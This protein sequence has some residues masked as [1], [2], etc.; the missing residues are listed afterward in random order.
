MCPAQKPLQT[1]DIVCAPSLAKCSIQ[2]MRS[3]QRKLL[4]ETLIIN[5]TDFQSLWSGGERGRGRGGG[6]QLNGGHTR[7][8]DTGI[9]GN[10]LLLIEEVVDVL[11]EDHLPNRFQRKLVLR[12]DLGSIQRVKV[13]LVLICNFHCLDVQLPLRKF[14]CTCIQD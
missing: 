7:G 13:K 4:H 14:T 1:Q 2:S 3:T 9:E 5:S 11:V 6:W 12:E 8:C 10:H